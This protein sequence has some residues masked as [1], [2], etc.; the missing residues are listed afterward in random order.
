MTAEEWRAV[1]GAPGYEA[2]S[3]GRVRSF[4]RGEPQ[5]KSVRL[6]ANKYFYFNLWID[7][8]GET[9]WTVHR[10]VATA[11][12]GPRPSG[13]VC[14]H[15]DGQHTNNRADNLAWGT[16]SQNNLDTVDH[17]M[18]A[19]ANKTHCKRGHPFDEANTIR[20]H[21]PGQINP[22]RACRQCHRERDA[23]YRD[24]Q[25]LRAAGISALAA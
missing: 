1:P 9:T 16:P 7:G 12:H 14:R 2:S 10:A 13:L 23:R 15:L 4:R 5:I 8:V 18:N 24:R 21:D 20:I 22:R 19:A 6:H 25:R 3:L 17:G 11:F